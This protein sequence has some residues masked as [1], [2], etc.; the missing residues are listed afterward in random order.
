MFGISKGAHHLNGRAKGSRASPYAPGV[1]EEQRA[2]ERAARRQAR[3]ERRRA[4]GRPLFPVEPAE[5]ATAESVTPRAPFEG[6]G[7]GAVR[8]RE[9]RAPER[10]ARAGARRGAA[11]RRAPPPARRLDRHLRDRDRP[12]A[13][14]RARAR[15]GRRLLLRRRRPDQRVHGRVPD[16][17]PDPRA[18]RRRRPLVGLRARLQRSARAGRA[19]AGLA[20]RVEPLLFDAARADGADVHLHPD[21]AVGDRAL[22]RPR[23][24]RR[25]R[26]HPLAHPLPDRDAARRLRRRRRDPEQLRPLHRAGALAGALE[27]RDHRR[28][29]DRRPAGG[30]D[31][32]AALRLRDLDPRRDVPADAAADAVA[33]HARPR[34]GAAARRSSTGATPRCGRSS[35]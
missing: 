34:R 7:R 24:R 10:P 2:R 27:H 32:H 26:R 12:L 11:G 17:E 30:L 4:Q 20:G 29:R 33:A 19:P 9:L 14:A 35:S 22:R 18:R 21:R 3:E 1:D 23:Q 25:A 13:R 31:R 15:D 8:D 5:A 6:L 28:A 16:P